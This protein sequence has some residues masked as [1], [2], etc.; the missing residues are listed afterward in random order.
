MRKFYV[1]FLLFIVILSAQDINAQSWDFFPGGIY[2][3]NIT[4]PQDFLGYDL[5]E[6]F[7]YHY[8]IFAYM[9]KL[10]EESDRIE[11]HTYGKTYE[12]RELVYLIISSPENLRR[13]EEI[14]ALNKKLADPRTM[15]D[16]SEAESIISNNPGIAWLSYGV[17]GNESCSSEAALLAAYQFA[18]GTD[19]LTTR[20]L[21]DLVI[22]LD[23]LL[24]PDGRD[25]YVFNY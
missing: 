18:A 13:I 16:Q 11:F 22:I 8:Q 7:T 6:K 3:R 5:G 17:H 20:L 2:N 9:K 4:R 10:A 1:L 12:G 23:P 19:Q 24:N 15:S 14:R 25:K 21:S